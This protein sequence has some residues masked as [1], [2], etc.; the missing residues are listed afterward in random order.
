MNPRVYLETT[1]IS[2]LAARSS[3]DVVVAAHQQLTREWWERRSRFD[4]YVSQAVV[5]EAANG[6]P[7]VAND[8]LRC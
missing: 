4:L 3:R 1:I 6:D 8:G 7:G 2:Y 5:D